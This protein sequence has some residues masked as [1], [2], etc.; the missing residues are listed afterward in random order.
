MN[1][2]W[3]SGEILLAQDIKH[4]ITWLQHFAQQFHQEGI[5]Y[6]RWL[7]GTNYGYGSPT[8]V[9]YP[10]LVSYVGTL[11]K[12]LPLTISQVLAIL[13]ILPVAIVGAS[14]YIFAQEKWGKCAALSGALYLMLC[15]YLSLN[16][17]SRGSLP[18]TWGIAW[19]PLGVWLTYRSLVYPKYRIVLTLFSGIFA[20][21]HLPT[22]LLSVLCWIPFILMCSRFYSWK[23]VLMTLGAVIL[24]WGL[25]AFYLA[26]AVL[27]QPLV[28]ISSMKGVSGGFSANLLF[29]QTSSGTIM[30]MIR[31]IWKNYV[32]SL[33]LLTGMAVLVQ[34]KNKREGVR[35]LYTLVFCLVIMFLMTE[36]S[37]IIWVIFKPIQMVQFPWRALGLLSFGIA[38]L[39]TISVAGILEK[40]WKSKFFLLIIG[41]ILLYNLRGVR[42]I[43]RD[44]PTLN[45]PR[46]F[47][48]EQLE[49]L[50]MAVHEP[51]A[52]TLKDVWEYRPLLSSGEVVP[53][54][55]IG[56]P[57]VSVLEGRAEVIVEK[58]GS[59]ERILQ[60]E[61]AERS[62]I[63]IRTYYYP[64]WQ[65]EVNGVAHPIVVGEDGTIQFELEGGSFTVKLGYQW[66][67][68]FKLGVAISVLTVI[69]L[70]VA[71]VFLKL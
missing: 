45:N 61:T 34:R 16:L 63:R 36:Y 40:S 22:L 35:L 5:L 14:F 69:G 64:A 28:N 11:L 41:L 3:L 19:I 10:P 51:F 25:V 6:P 56:Q 58:W 71:G 57:R 30:H 44:A 18:E 29:A 68:A 23:S 54:P 37:Q 50:Q 21:T 26:P 39:F 60:V 46:W 2:R 49:E 15:P 48:G 43:V 27:E 38:M 9:F 17:Y 13:Y 62:V 59:Y 4:H 32:V 33:C 7:A 31:P 52:N 55:Q 8:F 65:L 20:L 42:R 1:W 66:T 67:D 12:F 70:M 47:E 24:G 53:A